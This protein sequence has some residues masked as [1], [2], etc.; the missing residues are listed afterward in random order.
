[1]SSFT[2]LF[3]ASEPLPRLMQDFI[4]L[5]F[6]LTPLHQ[7]L[8]SVDQIQ[9]VPRIWG[10]APATSIDAMHDG[11]WLLDLTRIGQRRAFVDVVGIRCI[12]PTAH[13]G[14][15]SAEDRGDILDQ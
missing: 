7:S 12:R 11:K 5:P 10:T 6:R 2:F 8:E 9:D 15:L 4:R 13:Y 1:M 14:A 3:V